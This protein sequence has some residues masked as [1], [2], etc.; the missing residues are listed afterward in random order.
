MKAQQ[1]Y[2]RNVNVSTPLALYLLTTSDVQTKHVTR[3]KA[4]DSRSQDQLESNVA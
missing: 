4:C 3:Q 2:Q 1:R